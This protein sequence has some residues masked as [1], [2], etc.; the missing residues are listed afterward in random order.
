MEAG[1]D[2]NAVEYRG[3]STIEMAAALGHSEVLEALLKSSSANVDIQVS[4][5]PAAT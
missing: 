1:G 4:N 5:G 3:V 2:V